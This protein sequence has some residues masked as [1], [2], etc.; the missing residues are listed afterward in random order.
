MKRIPFAIS[1]FVCLGCNL[2]LTAEEAEQALEEARVAS[3]ALSLSSSSTT[4]SKEQGSSTIEVETTFT[5]GEAVK[6]RLEKI[7]DFIRSQVDCAE[8]EIDEQGTL[9]VRYGAVGGEDCEYLGQQYSGTHAIKVQRVTED[10]VVVSH[11]FSNFSNQKVTVS[12]WADV[13]WDREK[14]S[15][16]I[17][18]EL[19]W[20][21]KGGLDARGGEGSGDRTQTVLDGGLLEGIRVDG[22]HEWEG[23]SGSWFLEID[24]IEMRWIDPVPQDGLWR[25]TT[26]F[27]EKQLT[28][29]F[30]REDADTIEVTA[31]TTRR[32]YT[33]FVTGAG[34]RITREQ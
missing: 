17:E 23:K 31:K 3:Q 9:T 10:E 6:E 13:T 8:Y 2:T 12:G 14:E 7:R 5:I 1:I 4:I 18:H 32:S 29:S 34:G 28:L 16:R 22:E 26:P 15:R 19:R 25:L 11:N 20:Q 33:F 21:A 30:E 27:D 24:A